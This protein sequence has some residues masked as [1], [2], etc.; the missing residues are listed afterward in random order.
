MKHTSKFFFF[1]VILISF[2][3]S[4]QFFEKENDFQIFVDK[5]APYIGALEPIEAGFDGSGIIIAVI[6]TGVD[7]NHPDLFGFGQDGKVIGG[8]DYVDKDDSPMDTNGHGTEVAGIIAADGQLQGIAPKSKILA[9][10]VSQDGEA[11][12]SILIIKAIE[13]AVKDDADIIIIRR[14]KLMKKLSIK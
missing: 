5:S 1:S 4:L 13:Q 14:C 3:I 7:Y 6:D 11:V 10:R 12:S 8:Y 9:Y 2:V